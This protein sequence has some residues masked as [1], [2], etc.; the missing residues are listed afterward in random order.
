MIM[1][2]KTILLLV[3][4][5]QLFREATGRSP[6]LSEHQQPLHRLI[7]T[8]DDP[9]IRLRFAAAMIFAITARFS[10][11]VSFATTARFSTAVGFAITAR[12]STAVSFATTARFSTTARYVVTD[13]RASGMP[14][15]I[16]QLADHIL[17]PHSG[18]LGGKPGGLP[19]HQHFLILVYDFRQ[20]PHPPSHLCPIHFHS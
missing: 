14:K 1:L 7:Q 19:H 13:K 12:F 4:T 17:L 3:L 16:L 11:A 5:L 9:Q 20:H 8:M 2:G 6:V 15:I 18:R 10:T